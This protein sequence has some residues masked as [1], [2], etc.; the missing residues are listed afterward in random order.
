MFALL[1]DDTESA[2]LHP[3]RRGLPQISDTATCGTHLPGWRCLAK[4]GAASER[5]KKGKA[6][7]GAHE[8]DEQEEEGKKEEGQ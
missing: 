6:L 4:Y 3:E 7:R 1:P 5:D 2:S 8:G